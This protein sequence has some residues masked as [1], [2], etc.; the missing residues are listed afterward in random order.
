MCPSQV[1]QTSCNNRADRLVYPPLLRTLSVVPRSIANNTP[2]TTPTNSEAST[3]QNSPRPST[4]EEPTPRSKSPLARPTF[5]FPPQS[6]AASSGNSLKRQ[7]SS[8]T[9]R[10]PVHNPALAPQIPPRA[11]K[12]NHNISTTTQKKNTPPGHDISKRT[13]SSTSDSAP[14]STTSAD[15]VSAE[16]RQRIKELLTKYSQGLWAH[17]LPK[18]FI[19][20]YKTP[21]PENVLD[22]LPLLLDMCSVEYPIPHDKNRV[23][24][25]ESYHIL[26]VNS[27]VKSPWKLI[28][29][30]LQLFVHIMSVINIFPFGQAILYI[31]D[32]TDMEA[33][34]GQ[35]RQQCSCPF[36]SGLEVPSPKIT[37]GLPRP[38]EQYPSVL[39]TDAKS[40][41]AVTIR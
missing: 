37:P 26:Q 29:P 14:F 15:T 4:P 2:L 24:E 38:S 21:F 7:L 34:D 9:L 39:V 28:R 12:D 22:H 33:I 41:N 20:T 18:L 5:I 25:Y 36:P 10:S 13:F 8:V 3:T 27:T 30:Y 32:S 6:A 23:S 35:A 40:S 17:A 19:E 16:V 11:A 31:S 1:E